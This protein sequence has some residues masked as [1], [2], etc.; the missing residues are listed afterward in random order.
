MSS[1][2]RVSSCDIR[3]VDNGTIR[4]KWLNFGGDLDH[5]LDPGILERIFYII[6]LVSHICRY[7]YL[8]EVCSL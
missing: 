2:Y 7:W 3:N 5:C 4:N 1:P 8:E 6:A